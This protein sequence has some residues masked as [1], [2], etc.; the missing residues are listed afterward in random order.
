MLWLLSTLF[1][2]GLLVFLLTDFTHKTF[3]QNHPLDDH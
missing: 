1:F 2:G 3:D